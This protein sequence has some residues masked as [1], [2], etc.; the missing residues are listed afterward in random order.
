[1]KNGFVRG[2]MIGTVVGAVSSLLLNPHNREKA[3]EVINQGTEY[4]RG[5][6]DTLSS[7]GSWLEKSRHLFQGEEQEPDTTIL[8]TET[9]DPM[10]E[11]V[12]FLERRLEEL[13]HKGV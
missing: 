9:K 13:E 11:R 4:F 2:M 5:A 8:Q 12:A 3:R 10:A 7:A 6:E 1:M